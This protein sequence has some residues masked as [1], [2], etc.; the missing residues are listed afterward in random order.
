M[1][2]YCSASPCTQEEMACPKKKCCSQRLCYRGWFKRSSWKMER[3]QSS[4]SIP[5]RGWISAKRASQDCYWNVHAPYH[6][7]L[8]DLSC[9]RLSRV[10]W[11]NPLRGG[12]LRYI[13]RNWL[14]TIYAHVI[15]L[16]NTFSFKCGTECTRFFNKDFMK[17]FLS[18]R[19]S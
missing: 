17:M 13:N 8:R 3:G 1:K 15:L 10:E 5:W 4:W 11:V 16:Y 18:W 6:Q 9:R 12:M 14:R 7:D 2:G 19:V